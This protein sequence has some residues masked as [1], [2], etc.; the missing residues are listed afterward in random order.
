MRSMILNLL[1]ESKNTS[2]DLARKIIHLDALCLVTMLWENI[3][4]IKDI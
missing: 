4:E 3:S 1:D 2:S